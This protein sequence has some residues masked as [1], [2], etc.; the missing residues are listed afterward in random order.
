MREDASNDKL[1]TLI[2]VTGCGGGHQASA[3]AL[4]ATLGEGVPGECEIVNIQPLIDPQAEYFY[5]EWILKRGFSRFYWPWGVWYYRLYLRVFKKR[6]VRKLEALWRE[7]QPDQVI[8]CMPFVNSLIL[9]SLSK[10]GEIPFKILATDF[11]NP[12]PEYWYA[13]MP[14]AAYALPN[15]NFEAP[16]DSSEIFY[17]S[18]PLVRPEFLVRNTSNTNP[19]S[20][21]ASSALNPDT[22]TALILFGA[23]ASSIIQ[24]ILLRL[25]QSGRQFVVLCGKNESLKQWIEARDFKSN[26][27]AVGFTRDVASWMQVADCFIGKPGPGSAWEAL[28][29]GLPLMLYEDATIMKQELPVSDFVKEHA[30]G[31]TFTLQ[32]INEVYDK[33]FEGQADYCAR[34]DKIEREDPGSKLR[35]FYSYGMVDAIGLR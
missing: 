27:V 28:L 21:I 23:Y 1:K 7:R 9:E 10:F 30:L 20:E 5:N 32:T 12:Y 4:V 24:E 8:S 34:I 15:R 31:L 6:I 14:I 33:V 3:E 22:F 13:K 11:S 16:R 19:S 17:F 29:S 18:G 2:C 35:Q 26:V 25:D